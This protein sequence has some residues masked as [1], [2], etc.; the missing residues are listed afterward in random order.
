MFERDF[1]R[2]IRRELENDI[3]DIFR[4]AYFERYDIRLQIAC[5]H[6]LLIFLPY[7]DYSLDFMITYSKSLAMNFFCLII[8]PFFTL[9][10]YLGGWIDGDAMLFW[11]SFEFIFNFFATL[12]IL[13]FEITSGILSL[14]TKPLITLGFLIVYT[15]DFMM[16]F[17]KTDKNIQNNNRVY[18]PEAL[19]ALLLAK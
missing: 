14:A 16:D 4:G 8:L 19:D 12:M 2:Q 5:Q 9:G 1:Q 13:A 6:N 18:A 17:F 7:S 10:A 15:A 11:R 3:W